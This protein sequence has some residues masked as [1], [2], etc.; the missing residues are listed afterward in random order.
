MVIQR[1]T[2]DAETTPIEID[3]LGRSTFE[4][5]AGQGEVFFTEPFAAR[6]GETSQ[7]V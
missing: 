6:G 1:Y 5:G 4:V 2:V 7:S 3:R